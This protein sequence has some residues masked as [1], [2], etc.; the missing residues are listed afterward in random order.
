[1]S[2]YEIKNSKWIKVPQFDYS[3]LINGTETCKIKSISKI[4]YQILNYDAYSE[5]PKSI[6]TKYSIG[7]YTSNDSPTFI[8]YSESELEL[9]KAD[10]AFLEGMLIKK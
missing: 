3:G 9:S 4:T 5:S 1:M 6:R 8:W 7:L 10:F 2:K